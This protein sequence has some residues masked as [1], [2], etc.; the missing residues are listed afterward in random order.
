MLISEL[1]NNAGLTVQEVLS[2]KVELEWTPFRVKENLWRDF[3][4][5]MFGKESTKDLDKVEDIDKIHHHFT[6]FLGEKFHL[7]NP[8]F[9]NDPNKIR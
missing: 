1:L 8:E 7:E 4:M 9:P 6:R 5:R 2:E 3:Q